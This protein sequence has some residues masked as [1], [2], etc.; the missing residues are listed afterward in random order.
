[1]QRLFS[2]VMAV[3][4]VASA[5]G[6]AN[7]QQA[8]GAAPPASAAAAPINSYIAPIPIPRSFLDRE[9]AQRL[10]A[11]RQEA[12]A[13]RA[14]DGGALTPESRAALQEKLDRIQA[15]YRRKVSRNSNVRVH[16]DGA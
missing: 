13:Q 8:R 3:A 16:F 6:I 4:L 15:T 14:K 12:V 10:F 9:L 11:L 1:M 7:A 2:S 5:G